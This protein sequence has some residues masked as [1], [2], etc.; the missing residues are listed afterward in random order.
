MQFLPAIGNDTESWGYSYHGN[1]YE[2]GIK[3]SGYGCHKWGLGSIIGVHL[4]RWRGTIEFYL[5]RKPLGVAFKNLPQKG[6]LYP[7]VSSTA[8]K[9]GMRLVCALSYHND[10]AFECVRAISKN[11]NCSLGGISPLISQMSGHGEDSGTRSSLK[12]LLPPGL[13]SFVDNNCWFLFGSRITTDQASFTTDEDVDLEQDQ[14]DA[15]DDERY[16]KLPSENMAS[17]VARA[18]HRLRHP[19]NEAQ[20]R[21]VASEVEQSL[22][23]RTP[24]GQKRKQDQM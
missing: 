8:A 5:N 19:I 20:S 14:S 21:E 18:V 9:S 2:A 7:I 17:S 16:F 23:Q 13:C 12:K 4:D 3:S 1:L 24:T 6:P 11:L 10:L 15:T 22:K